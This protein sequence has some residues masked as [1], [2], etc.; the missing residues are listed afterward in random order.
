MI[1]LKTPAEIDRMHVAG[2]FVAEVLAGL[3]LFG[4]ERIADHVTRIG[5]VF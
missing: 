2:R 5:S 1:E 3:D 4:R